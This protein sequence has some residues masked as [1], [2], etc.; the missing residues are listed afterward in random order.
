MD[1][2]GKSLS[3]DVGSDVRMGAVVRGDHRVLIQAV[4]TDVR[5]GRAFGHEAIAPYGRR[6][7]RIDL[8][9]DVRRTAVGHQRREVPLAARLRGHR[10]DPPPTHP[11]ELRDRPFE[12]LTDGRVAGTDQTPG[13][14]PPAASRSP[15]D[16]EAH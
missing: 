4:V 11:P 16:P 10:G 8:E 1:A 7:A 15:P 12:R 5:P 13:Q 6:S 2:A 14:L 3:V 9:R